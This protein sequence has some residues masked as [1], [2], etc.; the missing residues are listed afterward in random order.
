MTKLIH[1]SP[2]NSFFAL[3]RIY[4]GS[5]AVGDSVRVLGE[6]Y[7]EDD[8]EDCAVATVGGVSLSTERGCVVVGAGD[9]VGAG[10]LVLVAGI[11]GGIK[12][13]A[14]LVSVGV[15]RPSTFSPLSLGSGAV[16]KVGSGLG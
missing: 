2:T 6:G 12:K 10:A 11:D 14:T 9:R 5:M 1:H 16:M 7:S 15:A 3:A 4:S 13:T 8:D